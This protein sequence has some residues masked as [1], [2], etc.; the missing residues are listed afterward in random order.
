ML[1]KISC[2]YKEDIFDIFKGVFESK[3]EPILRGSVDFML[4]TIYT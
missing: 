3:H 4:K 1:N 2:I